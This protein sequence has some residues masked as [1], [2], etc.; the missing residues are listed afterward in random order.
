[1]SVLNTNREVANHNIENRRIIRGLGEAVDALGSSIMAFKDFQEEERTRGEQPKDESRAK[2]FQ[3][4]TDFNAATKKIAETK[5]RMDAN[6]T[7]SAKIANSREKE[8]YLAS[9][10]GMVHRVSRAAQLFGLVIM[11][12]GFGMW[13][14]K[15]QRYRDRIVKACRTVSHASRGEGEGENTRIGPHLK[16]T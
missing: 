9:R 13:Y 15:L 14:S 11:V 8:D 1:M 12:F 4:I 3:T 7:L 5:S 16:I 10:L 2:A 6:E